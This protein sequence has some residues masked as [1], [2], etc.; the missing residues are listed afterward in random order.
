M[1]T[2]DLDSG[3]II[4]EGFVKDQESFVFAEIEDWAKTDLDRETQYIL[5]GKILHRRTGNLAQSVRWIVSKERDSVKLVLMSGVP[6]A[7]IH[8][9]GGTIKARAGHY[10]TVPFPA[11]M[12][13]AGMVYPARSF[14]NTFVVRSRV[15]NLI[16]MQQKG[17]NKV[18]P[19]FLL[20]K[21]VKIPKRQWASKA[22]E[23]AI[24]NLY[25]R[26]ER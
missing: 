3:V 9:T 5:A 7:R 12:P 16:I 22:V 24:P 2:F 11:A 23:K 10:L 1:S 17:K 6:Y 19:L 20:K 14:K 8:E 15:G 13:A 21:Q 26:I 4:L 25:R 18:I